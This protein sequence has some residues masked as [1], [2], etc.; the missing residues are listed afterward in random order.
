MRKTLAIALLLAATPA[1]AA[2]NAVTAT[3]GSGVTMRTK[4]VG[5]L[6]QQPFVG[7]GND[8]GVS[9]IGAGSTVPVSGSVTVSGTP[10]VN[11]GTP[12]WTVNPGTASSWGVQGQG[13]TTPGQVGVLNQAAVTTGAPT[14]VT[15][16]TSPLSLDLAGNLRTNCAAGCAGGSFNNNVDGVAT[17]ATNAQTAAWLYGWNGASFDRVKVSAY[18]TAPTGSGAIG[19]NAFVTNAVTAGRTT[20]GLNAQG[21]SPVVQPSA[22]NTATGGTAFPILASTSASTN[23]TL[24]KNAPAVLFG[25]QT[26]NSSTTPAWLHIFNLATAPV[27]GTSVAIKTMIIPGPAAGGG[28]N[29]ALFGPGGIALSAGLGITITGGAPNNDNT[30]Y[31]APAAPGGVVVQCDFE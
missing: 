13:S 15:G 28:G 31:T 5:A 1:M 3:P 29:N 9:L 17:S 21:A 2:D 14:Y 30:N 23:A 24:I 22:P 16:Q 11:Q 12:P 19:V 27:P 26:S 20:T 8:S 7:L 4:D 25:C 10:T 18:G 6:V